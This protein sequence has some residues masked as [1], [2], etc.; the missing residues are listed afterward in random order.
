MNKQK[1]LAVTVLQNTTR[2]WVKTNMAVI[3][4]TFKINV[5]EIMRIQQ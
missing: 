5:T 4:R 3:F 2:W 1:N